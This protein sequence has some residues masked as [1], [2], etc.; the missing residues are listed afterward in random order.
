[1]AL[2][3]NQ[4][5]RRPLGVNEKHGSLLPACMC[6]VG[7]VERERKSAPHN[8]DLKQPDHLP[9]DINLPDVEQRGLAHRSDNN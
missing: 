5:R 6:A 3:F 7:A 2:S 9:G 4:G 1:V 8:T